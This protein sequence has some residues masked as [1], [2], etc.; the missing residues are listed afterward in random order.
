MWLG[1]ESWD[2]TGEVRGTGSPRLAA[3][4]GAGWAGWCRAAEPARGRGEGAQRDGADGPGWQFWW[5]RRGQ[6]GHTSD[7]RAGSTLPT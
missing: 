1:T 2:K 5:G 3:L 7:T 6:W 4:A